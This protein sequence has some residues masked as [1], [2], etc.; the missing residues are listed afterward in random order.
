MSFQGPLTPE[1]QANFQNAVQP[2]DVYHFVSGQDSLGVGFKN[3]W[4]NFSVD[5]LARFYKDRG[6]VFIAGLIQLGAIPAVAFTLPI[7]YRPGYVED[8][9]Q[10]TNVATFAGTVTI[11]VNGDVTIQSGN[12]AFFSVAMNFREAGS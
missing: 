1:G 9:V 6:R 4:L 10:F 2:L 3:G 11:A 8:F 7:G 12:N 5:R